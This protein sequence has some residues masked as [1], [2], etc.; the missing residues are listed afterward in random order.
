MND[1]SA[2]QIAKLVAQCRKL[3][4]MKPANQADA[5]ILTLARDAAIPLCN[6]LEASQKREEELR[7]L[8]GEALTQFAQCDFREDNC[9][10]VELAGKRVRNTANV[11][12]ARVAELKGGAL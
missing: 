4:V 6:A 8:V 9:A 1:L 11:F 7:K 3:A 12:L 10:T 5:A 2:E